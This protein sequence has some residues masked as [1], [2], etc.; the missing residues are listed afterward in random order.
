MSQER[1][2]RTQP[3][4]FELVGFN[5]ILISILRFAGQRSRVAR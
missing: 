1:V 2:D 4:D 3:E 5:A